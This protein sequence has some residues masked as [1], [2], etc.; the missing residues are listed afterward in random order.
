MLRQ[1]KTLKF[2]IS[3]AVLALATLFAVSSV[4]TLQMLD[5]QRHE[6][7][8]LRLGTRLQ[9]TGNQMNMRA[10]NYLANAA[11][12]YDSY[13][14]DLQLYYGD[15]KSQIAE[16]DALTNGL[17]RGHFTAE[18]SS[19]EELWTTT[20]D[21][22]SQM[23]AEKLL[24]FW[25]EFRD[26]FEE[27]IGPDEAEPRLEWAA[28]HIKERSAELSWHINE[29]I[30]ALE[31]AVNRRHVLT[32]RLNRAAIVATAFLALGIL[33]WFIF[34]VLRPLQKTVH[35]FKNIAA[36][37][38]AHRLTIDSENEI[39]WLA[40]SVNQLA[41]RLD[42]LIQMLTRLQEGSDL[43]ETLRFAAETMPKL[44]PLDWVGILFVSADN[45]AQLE[46]AYRDGAPDTY[47][48][49]RFPIEG[50]PLG[51]SLTGNKPTR[52]HDLSGLATSD[53]RFRLL[54][55][56]ADLGMRDSIFMPVTNRS[57]TPG[58]LVFATRSA[59]TYTTEHIELLTNL[60]LLVT[61][62]F[63]RTLKLT[64]HA[65]LAAIGQFASGIAHELRSPLTT[66]NM[67]LDYFQGMNLPEAAKKR[68]NLAVSET[69][70]MTRLLDE[71]LLYAKPLQLNVAPITLVPF[72]R[73]LVNDFENALNLK[74]L[75]IDWSITATPQVSVDSDRLRQ[76]VINLLQNAIDASPEDSPIGVSVGQND[77]TNSAAFKISNA[78]DPIK[79]EH[80]GHVF[81]PFFTTK[82]YG[83]GL[84]LGIVRR[85][86]EA[87]GGEIDAESDAQRG[88][89]F[90][91]TLP[92]STGTVKTDD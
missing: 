80:M 66:L 34:K 19:M 40:G 38:F 11:R 44:V 54:R 14:R 51:T 89:V 39:G 16:I 70:R 27:R 1:L 56:L 43:D 12:D 6:D 50:T 88:T 77:E 21:D 62:S 17:A 60:S 36:G 91:V 41:A 45:M 68:A 72:M 81:D 55:L 20:M 65:R 53:K 13:Y 82:A 31:T 15:L 49:E 32:N 71:M 74:A 10:S 30:V 52:I 86:V 4:H 24:K 63:A 92:L 8:L 47:R 76:V 87:H 33:F 5:T 46:R 7:N 57:P 37:D 61:L 2:Q 3:I 78:G 29:L 90:T 75:T 67:A 79:P 64:E 58:V 18:Q 35:G 42:A 73:S 26:A 59:N 84:G 23:A 22:R 28:E 83:T 9:L 85:I 69:K 25:K 48:L